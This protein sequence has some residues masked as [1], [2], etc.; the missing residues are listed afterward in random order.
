MNEFLDKLLLHVHHHLL[1]NV[2]IAN[3]LTEL[4]KA[5]FSIIVFISKENSFVNNLLKLRVLQVVA[6]HHFQHL[7]KLSV[8][9]ISIVVYVV[10]SE[11]KSEFAVLISLDTKLRNTLNEFLEVHLAITVVIKYFYDPLNKRILL[12]LR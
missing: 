6:H 9:D 12:Q 5:D 4:L 2:S 7:E 10:Y 1:V 11:G 8:G 3:H